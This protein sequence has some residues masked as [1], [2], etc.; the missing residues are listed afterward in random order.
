[1]DL[2]RIYLDSCNN[3]EIFINKWLVVAGVIAL[4]LWIIFNRKIFSFVKSFEID[5]TQLGIGSQKIKFKPNNQSRQVAYKLWVELSTRKIGLPIDYEHDVIIDIYH[6]WYEFFKLTREL[7][8]D[9]PVSK[10][11]SDDNTVAL[12]GVAIDVLNEGLRP[13]LT[14]W[15]AR[16]T[17]WYDIAIKKAGNENIDPQILQKQ[18]PDYEALVADMRIVNDKLIKYRDLVYSIATQK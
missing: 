17:R 2:L 16:F 15:Q 14:L 8:K 11:R 7:I 6:S 13:H 9:I 5:E 1:M 12:V 4:V 3:P 10:I 18:Y